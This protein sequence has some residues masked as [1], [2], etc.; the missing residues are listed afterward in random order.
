MNVRYY[1]TA[2]R[3][4]DRALRLGADPHRPVRRG[5]RR[6]AMYYEFNQKG[7]FIDDST[8]AVFPDAFHSSGWAPMGQLLAGVEWGIGPRLGAHDR[9]ALP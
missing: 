6:A 5:R 8:L 1:L 2:A 4:P 3:T 9:S 7:D